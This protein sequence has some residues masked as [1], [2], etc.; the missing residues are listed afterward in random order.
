MESQIVRTL[1]RLR[2]V[3]YKKRRI[4]LQSEISHTFIQGRGYKD[5]SWLYA[6]LH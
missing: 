1:F 6:R 4:S 3:F 5:P 2:F